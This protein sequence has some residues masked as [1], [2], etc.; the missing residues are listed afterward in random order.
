MKVTFAMPAACY[1]RL[2]QNIPQESPTYELF[3]RIVLP[4]RRRRARFGGTSN[5]V[6]LQ[7]SRDEVMPVIGAARQHCPEAVAQ[8]E[9]VLWQS[10]P[11]A[12]SR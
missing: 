2:L 3:Q 4:D 12:H 5:C 1:E 6:L 11:K 8:I 7:C 9:D 10:P